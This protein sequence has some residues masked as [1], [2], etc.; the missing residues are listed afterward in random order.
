MDSL[1]IQDIET[2]PRKD[3]DDEEDETSPDLFETLPDE[4][5]VQILSLLRQ[6]EVAV[7]VARINQRF[8][9]LSKVIKFR[10][11]IFGTF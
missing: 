10:A 8:Y 7:T 11:L 9:R 3:D 5:L 2:C 4:I 6:S 1:T